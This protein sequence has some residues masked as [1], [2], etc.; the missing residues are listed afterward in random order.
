M[1]EVFDIITPFF[2]GQTLEIIQ[3]SCIVE[4][5]GSCL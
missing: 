5:I 1:E 2:E 3:K 4:L